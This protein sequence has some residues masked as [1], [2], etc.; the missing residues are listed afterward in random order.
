MLPPLGQ[1]PLPQPTS[2]VA[3]ASD[4]GPT[5]LEGLPADVL[6]SLRE[7]AKHTLPQPYRC[8]RARLGFEGTMLF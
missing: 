6:H 4:T 3:S 2:A 1:H 5:G 7:A 8:A